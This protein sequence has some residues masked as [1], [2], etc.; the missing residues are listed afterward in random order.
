VDG[1]TMKDN[2]EPSDK[3]PY[4]DNL[5]ALDNLN[6][7]IELLSRLQAYDKACRDDYEIRSLFST[8]HKVQPIKFSSRS[9]AILAILGIVAGFMAYYFKVLIL[10]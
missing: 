4:H 7:E 8:T 2:S 5:D 1:V 3:K 9:L 10:F 6:Q